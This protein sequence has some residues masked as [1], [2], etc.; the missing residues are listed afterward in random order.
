[1]R[2][3]RSTCIRRLRN[4]NF[5]PV[6]FASPRIERLTHFNGA[7]M[8][9]HRMVT[10]SLA[11]RASRALARV[12]Q[13]ILLNSTPRM[14]R[15]DITCTHARKQIAHRHREPATVFQRIMAELDRHRPFVPRLGPVAFSRSLTP[16]DIC[17]GI[18]GENANRCIKCDPRK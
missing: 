16:H 7:Q 10:Y 13:G 14:L 3:T 4:S 1:M 15:I 17:C 6:R 8:P 5:E 2:A 12:C 18:C 9:H 11:T